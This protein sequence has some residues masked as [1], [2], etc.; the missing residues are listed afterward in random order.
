VIHDLLAI[1]DSVQDSADVCVV[2]AGI[3]GLL[4]AARLRDRGLRVVVLESGPCE[5]TERTNSLNEVV[6]LGIPYRGAMHGR[7]RGLGGTSTIWGGALIPFLPEDMSARPYLGLDD[8][9]VQWHELET[10]VGEIEALCQVDHGPFDD[11][12]VKWIGAEA[13]VPSGDR[14]LLARFAKW[15]SFRRRNIAT[16]LKERVARDPDLRIWVNATVRDFTLD[17]SGIR[18]A[19]VTAVHAGG[20]RITVAARCFAVCTGAIESTRLLLWLDRVHGAF[21]ASPALGCYFFDH[22]STFAA[23]IAPRRLHDL[24]RLAGHRFVGSTVRSLRYELSP[25]VQREAKVA[26]AFG[27]IAVRTDGPSGFD[28]VRAFLQ[29]VQQTGRPDPK[30]IGGLARNLP[31]LL[32]L[33]AWRI[34]YRQLYWPRPAH[35]ELHVCVE[36][37]PYAGNRVALAEQTDALGMARASI[38]WNVYQPDRDALVAFARRFGAFWRRH[39][40]ED[41]AKLKWRFDFDHPDFDLAQPYDIFHPGGTTRMGRDSATAVV[42]RNLRTFALDNLFVA[43]TSVFP[44]GASA[45]PT[46]TLML[47]A[48]RLGD[49]LATA[50]AKSAPDIIDGRSGPTATA[51]P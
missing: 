24:N 17:S 19:S 45:N 33:A 29:S 47:F 2:G 8:W 51:R 15:A 37:L 3:A 1:E 18:L 50:A 6:H 28:A 5:Q 48:L 20:R 40:L 43:S 41:I 21:R 4:L 27:H 7:T 42:D 13:H 25:T 49:H 30:L 14:D 23:D 34:G 44:T 35:Y 9:P 10:Y 31:Y 22:I 26:S 46:L 38:K 11:A 32:R 16:L 12:F 36:Q 39:G